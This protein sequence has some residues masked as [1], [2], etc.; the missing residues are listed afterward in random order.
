MK[1]D[2]IENNPREIQLEEDLP[3]YMTEGIANDIAE[4]FNTPISGAY[5]WDNTVQDKRIKK[6]K[7][8]IVALYP[9]SRNLIAFK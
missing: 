4:I 9:K 5:N 3:P 7:K 2:Y 8:I 6:L 1:I